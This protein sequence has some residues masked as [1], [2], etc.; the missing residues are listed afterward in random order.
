M[1]TIL[2]SGIS[3]L[4]AKKLKWY[5]LIFKIIQQSYRDICGCERVQG[6]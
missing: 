1:M 4:K 6:A 3:Q 2:I 5:G